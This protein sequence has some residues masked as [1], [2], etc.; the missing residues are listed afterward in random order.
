[1][2]VAKKAAEATKD[3]FWQEKLSEIAASRVLDNC[4]SA[5]MMGDVDEIEAWCVYRR[6]PSFPKS[7]Q[8][9]KFGT[10]GPN[11]GTRSVTQTD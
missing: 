1:M 9:T 8:T 3:K 10:R 7:V 11:T 2:S 4:M 6:S 5:V